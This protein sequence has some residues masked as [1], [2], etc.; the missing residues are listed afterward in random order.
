MGSDFRDPYLM[1]LQSQGI[2]ESSCGRGAE[3]VWA[4]P[5]PLSGV[6]LM[7]RSG[8]AARPEGGNWLLT[9]Y[10]LQELSASYASTLVSSRNTARGYP[11]HI[12]G[13]LPCTMA[14]VPAQRPPDHRQ[15]AA[16]GDPDSNGSIIL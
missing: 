13:S 9:G 4:V 8:E 11:H 5:K 6:G 14:L 2:T 10:C 1:V 16:A 12:S 3:G 7:S 15:V